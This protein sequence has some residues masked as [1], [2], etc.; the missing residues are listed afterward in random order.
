MRSIVLIGLPGAGKSSIGRRLAQRLG[1]PFRDADAEIEAAAGQPITEI[2]FRYGEPHFREGE[3]RVIARLLAG[4]PTV[5]ATGGGAYA[6]AQTREAIRASGAL[7][8]WLQVGIPV[9]LPRVAGRD[10]RPMFLNQDPAAVLQRLMAARH[11][12]YAEAD[13][14]V[15]CMEE[16]PEATTDRVQAAITAYA[17]PARLPVALAGRGYDVV[18]GEGL[19]ARAGGLI[20][21]ALPA[22]R[23]AVISDA[24]VAALH[25]PALRRG[26]EEAGIEVRASLTVP[27]GEGSKSLATYG[28][29]MEELLAAGIDRSTAV[30]ALGGGVVGDLAGFVAASALRGLPFVQVPTTLLAQV[31]S[32]VGGKTGINLRAGKN[33]AG[34]FHQ[35]RIVLAD[36]GVL[37]TLPARELRAGYAEVAKHGLLQGPLWDW[38]EAAGAKAVA[39]E[40]AALRHAVLESCRLKS[41]VVAADEREESAEGGRALLNL[42]HTFGHAVEAECGYDGS[43]LHGEAVALGLGLAARLSARLGLCDAALPGRVEAHLAAV[44]LPARLADL[45]RRFTVEALMGRMRKD[46]KV[47]DGR[48]RFVL[49]HGPGQAVTK[50][51]V[52]PAAVEALLREASCEG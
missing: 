14:V 28:A 49:L 3:R 15:N 2:F 47:R 8:V 52:E 24:S 34:A 48:L 35:P 37:A 22:R 17:A 12:L 33:L 29:V 18:I 36:T 19:L 1:V 4:P 13:L 7:T 45:P 32:S 11:P 5:L 38:C 50:G 51:D 26:L 9:L 40:A 30:V 23:V 44:G 20:A 39:G 31:D 43:L 42:G 10:T 6:D 16:A 25:L 41:A 21:P 46:K 27:P